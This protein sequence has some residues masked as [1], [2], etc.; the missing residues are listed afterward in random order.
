MTPPTRSSTTSGTKCE[1]VP[2]LL[3]QLSSRSSS[4]CFAHRNPAVFHQCLN[5]IVAVCRTWATFL[6]VKICQKYTFLRVNTGKRY[7]FLRVNRG[8]PCTM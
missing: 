6:R 2:L 4:R 1:A 7:T 3:V 8:K 5:I